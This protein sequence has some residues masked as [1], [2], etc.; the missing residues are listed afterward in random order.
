MSQLQSSW[1]MHQQ[2]MA[3]L[4][5]TDMDT[6]AAS[7]SLPDPAGEF[8]KNMPRI[9]GVC[10]D[11]AT[12]F[13]FNAMTCEGCKGFFRRSMKR[14]AMFTCPFNGDCKITKDNRRHCQACRL[15]RCVD[16]GMMKEFILTDEEVQRKREMILKRKEEEA[17]KESL[18]PKLSEEQ[19]KVIDIL[20]EAHRKTYDPTYS[21]FTKFRPPVRSNSSNRAAAR[22][23][24]ILTQDLSLEDSTDLF[25]SDAFSTFPESVEPQMFSNL[26]LS[27]ENDE[28]S[29]MNIDFS[30]LSMLPH[31]A[32]L[33]SY[34]IQKVIGFAK[35]IPGFRSLTAED[36]IAL[37]K[38]SAIEVIMLRSN[39]SFTLEDMSWTCGSNEF[40]YRISD[41]TQAGHNMDLLEPLV[42]FQVG[43]KKLN[44]HEEEHV[45]LMAICILS[46]GR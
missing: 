18:K 24:S 35:M 5:D 17:L 37:L 25:G 34:S 2:S 41:V 33:V 4:P 44:L 10:G 6:M 22:S 29:S 46:P 36:Q 43:L 31:L 28:S 45:L 40:K 32:D 1:E 9:C 38:S 26:V 16:I 20:L 3:Y 21:D 8:D 30:H 11:R 39:Q 19:Q 14:K 13:H 12:G 15:K 23:S 42:K 27:E 7:T